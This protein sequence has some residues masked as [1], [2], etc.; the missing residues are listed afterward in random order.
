VASLR[1]SAEALRARA[2][3]VPEILLKDGPR[4]LLGKTGHLLRRTRQG[5][6]SRCASFTGV[7]VDDQ[8]RG[9]EPVSGRV[10]G[11]SVTH[12]P[13]TEFVLARP[14]LL[15]SIPSELPGPSAAL[16]LW[17]GMAVWAVDEAT[18]ATD[19]PIGVRGS[20][21]P[22]YLAASV[23]TARGRE[24]ALPASSSVDP[25]HISDV[26]GEGRLQEGEAD[27]WIETAGP[28]SRSDHTTRQVIGI[29]VPRQA[30]AERWPGAEIH[31]SA[32]VGDLVRSDTHIVD[33][34][35]YDGAPDHPQWLDPDRLREYLALLG[36][37]RVTTGHEPPTIEVDGDPHNERSDLG[38]SLRE[39]RSGGTGIAVT[40]FG[41]PERKPEKRLVLREAFESA[42]SVKKV[43]VVGTG[44]WPL[45]MIVRRI[46]RHEGVALRGACDRRP[47]IAHLARQTLPFE[48]VTTDYA[49][50]LSDDET[51]LI[52]VASYHGSHAPLAIQS[53]Q[54]NKHTFVEKPPVVSLEQLDGLMD[55]AARSEGFLHVGYN[56]RF[57]PA[58]ERLLDEMRSIEGPVSVTVTVHGIPLPQSHWYYW[59]SNGNRIISNVCHFI[60]YALALVPDA[61]PVRV[62]ATPS[63]RGRA[64]RNV[65]VSIAFD[66][67]SLSSITYT[68]RGCDRSTT[69]Y[70]SYRIL[71][72][73][74]TGEL[75][76]FQR[77]RIYRGGRKRA[78]WR[79]ALDI[80][81]RAQMAAVAQA[82]HDGGPPPVELRTTEVS[83]RAVLAAAESAATGVPV[84]LSLEKTS[85]RDETRYEA[86]RAS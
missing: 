63:V 80:G 84:E 10:A 72:G 74:L 65:A 68:D 41:G 60:D 4:I 3:K 69:Y 73:D 21:I 7:V 23:L 55:A 6:S 81:H 32:H 47:E 22:A 16:L 62:S 9:G 66:D 8:S 27:C 35:Y 12:P 38:S 18:A 67:G 19:G 54:A 79:G 29:D 2:R 78:S 39:A 75:E 59:P 34:F 20:G 53:L 44:E 33:L 77:L 76:D 56:R 14:E 52:V 17:G 83:A 37:G 61:R 13:D 48:Y 30:L 57:A 85:A 50:L 70:Q 45:G 36:R 64:D 43:S 1:A 58:T 82:L 86:A 26:L 40:R 31:R 71:K 49:E 15:F 24:V 42:S 46:L 28:G 51:D 25:T 5:D 11:V